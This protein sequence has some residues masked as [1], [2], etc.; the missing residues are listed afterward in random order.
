[1]N[2]K[3]RN[4]FFI[5]LF[6]AAIITPSCNRPEGPTLIADDSVSTATPIPTATV[7]P[8]PTPETIKTEEQQEAIEVPPVETVVTG[9]VTVREEISSLTIYAEPDPGAAAV[10]NLSNPGPFDGPRTLETTGQTVGDFL[11]VIVPVLPNKTTGWVF[12]DDVAILSSGQRIVVDLSD[13]EA[14]L[15]V[16][17]VFVM[18]APVAIGTNETPT[19]VLE[20]IIDVVWD[21]ITSETSFGTAY[22]DTLFGLNQH[23]EVLE[24]FG[25]KRPAIAI[26]GTPE[27]ELIG[28]QV[29]NGCIR[30][31]NDDIEK[32]AEYVRLGARVQIVN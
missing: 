32:F 14:S 15:Y 10:K 26:H 1:M 25:G 8:P 5:L 16:D 17:D 20:A 6:V 2:F 23:S 22:G 11:E 12:A 3:G 4:F 9:F 30:M 13:R 19:P 29:S 7:P 31:R 28:L 18:K 27:P 21:R 24:S